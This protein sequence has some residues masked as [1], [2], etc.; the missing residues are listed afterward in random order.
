MVSD[1]KILSKI[2]LALSIFNCWQVIYAE[3]L[4]IA[5]VGPM[6]GQYAEYGTQLLIGAQK[7][8]DDINANGGIL[9]IKLSIE[10]FDDECSAAKAATIAQDIINKK[11]HVAVIGHMC[12][13]SLAS[14]IPLYKESNTLVISP[15]ATNNNLLNHS[16]NIFRLTGTNQ[17]QADIII[18]FANN[19]FKAKNIAIIGNSSL[20]SKDLTESINNSMTKQQLS[21]KMFELLSQAQPNVAS[22]I[23][24]ILDL[25]IDLIIF[26]G[27]YPHFIEIIKKLNFYNLQIPI[28]T[29]D[30]IAFNDFPT[31]AGG[32]KAV[33][34]VLYAYD[35]P[36]TDSMQLKNLTL[37]THGYITHS[38]A[39]VE[40]LARAL[41]NNKTI[42]SKNLA[43]YLHYNKFN[44]VLGTIYWDSNG[45]LFD[46][47][48]RI[49]LWDNED[50]S[51]AA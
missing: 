8:V 22:T 20:Y 3:S 10:L 49:F 6:S 32:A 29:G 39:A 38:Y 45:E 2:I 51:K 12:S 46:H 16:Q 21:P 50:T 9:G 42:T 48:F 34:P 1:M 33:K 44:T 26:T 4:P 13:D 25:K 19:K 40:I 37:K 11:T 30:S 15:S 23:K 17:K 27:Y 24:K 36:T 43:D 41:Q 7:A 28:I 14:A 18:E 31:K 5:I 35:L 47:N